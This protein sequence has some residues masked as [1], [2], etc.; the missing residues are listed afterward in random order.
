MQTETASQRLKRLLDEAESYCAA[1]GAQ[2]THLRRLVLE[3]LMTATGPVKA[4]DL[5]DSLRAKGHRLTPATVYRILEFLLHNGLVHRV[6]AI[7]A[8]VACSDRH[9]SAHNPV[10]VVCP[11]CQTTLEINDEGLYTSIF[12]RLGALGFD[13]KDGAIEVRGVCRK[14]KEGSVS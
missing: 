12:N 3:A 5:M 2:L 6:N 1:Q 10:I 14:C 4:Y 7:N 8:F 11:G 9:R 13:I